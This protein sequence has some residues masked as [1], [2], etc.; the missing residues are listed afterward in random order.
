MDKILHDP[1][2]LQL[3]MSLETG[4]GRSQNN[5]CD[6]LQLAQ[7]SKCQNGSLTPGICAECL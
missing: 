6:P 1:I 4:I 7:I 2:P 3:T 5:L